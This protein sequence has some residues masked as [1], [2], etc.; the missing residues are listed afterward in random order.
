[1]VKNQLGTKKKETARRPRRSPLLPIVSFSEQM[2]VFRPSDSD[3]QKIGSPYALVFDDQSR[4]EITRIVEVYFAHEHIESQRVYLADAVKWIDDIILPL[5][6]VRAGMSARTDEAN[7]D[8]ADYGKMIVAE[9][10]NKLA[11]Q[12][13]GNVKWANLH[14]FA[15]YLFKACNNA[16]SAMQ[17]EGEDPLQIDGFQWIRMAN[18]L[19][20]FIHFQGLSVTI[21]K[22]QSK[23]KTARHS[24]IVEFIWE[25][26]NL[27]P[28]KLQR[29]GHSK[30]ALAKALDRIRS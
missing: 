26:Q 20:Q 10:L 28:G 25:L 13:G 8:A 29:H 22:G 14:R 23:T 5:S 27:F 12:L 15:E 30:Q 16:K 19:M 4:A 11:P 1:M 6:K 24:P 2:D 3:W 18:G 7:N 17:S 9:E 21:S